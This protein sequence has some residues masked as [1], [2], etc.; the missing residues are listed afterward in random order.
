MNVFITAA[1][2][3]MTP[4]EA[5]ECNTEMLLSVLKG[6]FGVNS[7][8]PCHFLIGHGATKEPVPGFVIDVPVKSA[9]AMLQRSR[10]VRPTM[11]ATWDSLKSGVGNMFFDGEDVTELPYPVTSIL[12]AGTEIPIYAN[13]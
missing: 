13:A 6:G 11:A 9:M 12:Y 5:L 4:P 8:Q 2:P 10:C 7:A 1:I 3:E